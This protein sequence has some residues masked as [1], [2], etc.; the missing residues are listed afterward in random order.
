MK[1]KTICVTT[2]VNDGE[3]EHHTYIEAESV[4]RIQGTNSVLVNNS[5]KIDFG[6]GIL[7]IGPE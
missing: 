6:G 7:S 4:E 3:Y 2:D 1:P 5:I